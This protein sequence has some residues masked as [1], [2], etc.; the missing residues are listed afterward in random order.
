MPVTIGVLPMFH[1][2]GLHAYILD[3]TF[4]QATYVILDKW[5]TTKYLNSIAKHVLNREFSES[6][7]NSISDIARRTSHLS[8][9][10]YT[11]S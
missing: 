4:F 1:A 2:Y 10:R 7:A 6:V 8:R 3:M 9:R 11:S 5:N